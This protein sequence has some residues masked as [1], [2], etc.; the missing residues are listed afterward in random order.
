MK[1]NK[2]LFEDVL[3]GKLKGTFVSREKRHY[4]SSLL[5][6]NYDRWSTTHPYCVNGMS[7]S[8]NGFFRV[9]ITSGPLDI[10]DFIPDTNTKENELTIEIPNG[11]IVDWDESKKQN[12]IV[13]K[14]KRLTYEDVCIAL[15]NGKMVY[16]TD[17][18]GNIN[19]IPFS[20]LDE[21]NP[22][23]SNNAFTKHQLECILAKNMLANV[24]KY[25]NNGWRPNNNEEKYGWFIYYNGNCN[26]FE[27]SK[28]NGFA[29]DS[30]VFFK[31]KELAQQAIEILGE[32]TVKLALEPLGV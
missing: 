11:K 31:S 23:N 15:Y 21:D 8:P 30:N 24:A 27:F 25:L 1:I 22:Y 16:Y 5:R 20:K 12:K 7:Y 17:A 32:E 4:S 19:S 18:K 28:A 29:Y 3:S 13:L 10:I 14:D 2:Q 9:E 6:R 26:E